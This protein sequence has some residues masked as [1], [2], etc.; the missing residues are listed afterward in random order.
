MV[1]KNGRERVW[2]IAIGIWKN[3]II[4]TDKI[5]ST[6]TK[7]TFSVAKEI[8]VPRPNVQNRFW[9]LIGLG[10]QWRHL[11]LLESS[12]VEKFNNEIN[13]IMKKIAEIKI[14]ENS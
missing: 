8:E 1:F 10:A 3:S 12:A 6:R 14:E 5:R 9:K 4:D 7:A 11:H 2:L 13:E